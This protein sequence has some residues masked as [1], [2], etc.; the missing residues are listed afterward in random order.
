MDGRINK[1]DYRE[2]RNTFS[3]L[4]SNIQTQKYPTLNSGQNESAN[5]GVFVSYQYI[6]LSVMILRECKNIHY[7]TRDDT[8]GGVHEMAL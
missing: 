2:F 7:V 1:L 8:N 6:H 3:S 5:V 4:E